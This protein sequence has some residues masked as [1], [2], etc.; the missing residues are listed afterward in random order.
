MRLRGGND[1]HDVTSLPEDH[2]ARESQA[3]EGEGLAFRFSIAAHR[4]LLTKF[5][6]GPLML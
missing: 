6:K 1:A 4:L 2:F 3:A 5:E